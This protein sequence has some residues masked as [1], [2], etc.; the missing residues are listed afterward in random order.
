MATGARLYWWA[1]PALLLIATA[2]A[3]DD[4]TTRMTVTGRVLDPAGKPVS[5]AAVT[6]FLRSRL[7]TGRPFFSTAGMTTAFERR[8]DGSGRFRLELPRTSTARH[9]ALTITALAPGYGMSWAE[10]DP[11][12]ESPTVDVA[13]RPEQIIRGRL[14]D[15]KGQAAGG[16]R[17]A[18]D[19]ARYVVRGEIVSI[20]RPG[21]YERPWLDSPAWP[22][23]AISDGDGRFT[24]RG[25]GRGLSYSLFTDDPRFSPYLGWIRTDDGAAIPGRLS[26]HVGG[27]RV[28]PGPNPKPITIA[29]QPARSLTGRVT[30]AETGQPVPHALV[31]AFSDLP[32]ETDSEGR[33]RVAASRVGRLNQFLIRAASLDGGPYLVADKEGEWPRGALEQS[34]D[35]ALTRGVVVRGKVVEEGTGRPV[36]GAVVRVAP[37]RSPQ[38]LAGRSCVPA[39][40]GPDGTYRV[41]APPGPGYL[42]VQASND[43]VIREF[44]G[45]GAGASMELG[46]GHG[47]FYAHGHRAVDLKASEPD[48]QIDITLRRGATIRG[49]VIGPDGQPVPDA[50][51]F[52]RIILMT[53]PRGGWGAFYVTPNGGG[54]GRARNGRFTLHGLDADVEVPVFFL[55]PDR[56]LGATVRFSGR[57][58]SGGPVTVRLQPCGTVRARL[59]DAEGQPVDHYH[60]ASVMTMIVTPGSVHRRKSAKDDPLFADACAPYEL[61]PVNN[62]NDILSDAQGRV[63]FPALIPGATYRVLDRSAFYAGG[64]QE[65]RKE[66]VVEPGQELELGDILIARPPRRD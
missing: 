22:A 64:E 32:S 45:D 58:G 2:Q 60:A 50:L 42:V 12:A 40:T 38:Q 23:S 54:R 33:F 16:V 59:V 26:R 41:V 14:F 62:P 28:E 7:W 35:L 17:I 11:D 9:H 56:K 20:A 57:S 31:A 61:D 27:I 55:S 8:C 37:Y 34:V 19:G 25:L 46:P 29:L 4:P 51:V 36:A 13:L 5:H 30:D 47:R 66:F 1:L 52:T 39:A 18:V 21:A 44:G 49:R 63:T 43:Y 24:L 3:N 15:L 10:L 53:H 65:I 48:Q 6:V